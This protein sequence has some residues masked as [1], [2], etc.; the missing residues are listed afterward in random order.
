MRFFGSRGVTLLELVVVLLIVS[1]LASIAT[2]VYSGYVRRSQYTA[3]RATIRELELAASR[4][5]IDTGEYPLSS[6]G[7]RIAPLSSNGSVNTTFKGTNGC[8]YLMVCLLHSYSGNA[9]DP[10]S[11]R[12]QGPYLEVDRSNLG[13]I[14][15]APIT[16]S[17]PLAQICL[18]DPW[19][20]PY[21]YV[22]SAEYAT[23]RATKPTGT[24]STE[25]YYNPSTCQIFSLG[26]D[27][28]TP[29]QPQ[30]GTGTDDITNF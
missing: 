6:S 5:D 29:V 24:P 27:G 22:R 25:T 14:T 10:A 28:T 2:S 3:A 18:L 7:T 26:P 8:G 19:K 1:I 11:T 23:Y 17:T 20:Q 21:F 16:S 9:L 30:N 13:T 12:W 15:G 4:Y